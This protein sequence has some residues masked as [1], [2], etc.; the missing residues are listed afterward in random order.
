MTPGSKSR[1]RLIPA[2]AGKTV[3]AEAAT[4]TATAHPRVGGENRFYLPRPKRPRGSSPRGRG[5]RGSVFSVIVGLRLIP[6]W[7]GKTGRGRRLWRR[8]TAHPRVGGENRRSGSMIGVLS[9]SSPR[10]RGK[11]PRLRLRDRARGLIP[12]WAGKTTWPRSRA[13][14]MSAHPRVGGEN[15]VTSSSIRR[16]PGSSPRGRGKPRRSI[17][18]YSKA[19][20]IPAWA[21]KTSSL[22]ARQTPRRAHPRVGGENGG[23]HVVVE[24]AGGSSPRGRG[25][26]RL[27]LRRPIGLRAHPRVGGENPLAGMVTRFRRGSSPRGRGKLGSAF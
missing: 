11:P 10:G 17:T 18:R 2:W 27:R 24:V 13:A 16:R 22:T 14:A 7:A 19:G 23:P 5:K 25:K 1:D 12:A 26:R 21:G 8:E 9:G 3:A 15:P 4:S 20:L 6:A